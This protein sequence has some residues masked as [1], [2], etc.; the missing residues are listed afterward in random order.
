MKTGGPAWRARLTLHPEY[1][2]ETELLTSH[3]GFKFLAPMTKEE[4]VSMTFRWARSAD[5][6]EDAV[7]EGSRDSYFM[8]TKL[9]RLTVALK[10]CISKQSNQSK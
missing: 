3:W 9:Q 4:A 2:S 6:Q 1:L 10:D 7:L 8:A 5:G